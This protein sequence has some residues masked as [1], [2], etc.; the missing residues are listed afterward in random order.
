LGPGILFAPGITTTVIHQYLATAANLTYRV[1]FLDS[2]DT[3]DT[4]VLLTAAS[5]VTD[6]GLRSRF[7]AMFTPWLDIVG[8]A[9]GST[10]KVPPSGAVAGRFSAHIASGHSPNEPAAGEQ[11]KLK[12]VVNLEQAFNDADRVAL[13]EG[14]VNVI[15]NL[16]G[17]IKIYGWR[18]TADPVADKDWR[19]LGNS[20]MHRQVASLCNQVGERFIFRQLDGQR[21]VVGEFGAAL[22]GEVCLPLFLN[23]SLFGDTPDEAYKVDT[24]ESVNTDTT[25]ADDQLRAIVSVRMSPF[26]EEVNIEI[27]KYL[28]TDSIPV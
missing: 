20:I 1:A 2:P 4:A 22:S 26:G 15:R 25:M 27:V 3:S 16:Y 13:N 6:G 17:V 5:S 19:S 10:R 9:A 24:G 12:S 7:A 11:G 21:R 23:G 14:G 28:I 18:S 8:I